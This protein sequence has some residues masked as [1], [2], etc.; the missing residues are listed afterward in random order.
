MIRRIKDYF[1]TTKIQLQGAASNR[2]KLLKYSGLVLGGAALTGCVERPAQP[3]E[4]RGHKNGQNRGSM[5]DRLAIRELI[6]SYNAAVIDN[7]ADAWADNWCADGVWNLGEESDIVG[8]ETI[9]KHWQEA[10][11]I[12]DFVGMFAQPKFIRVGDQDARA[13]WHTNELC[14]KSDGSMLRIF[15]LYRDAYRRELTGW[16]IAERRYSIL[17]ME[18]PIYEGNKVDDWR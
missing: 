1:D 11:Q 14:R 10:M 4:K 3:S 15:G 17:L 13:E 8:R 12:F 7:D 18:R 5:E 6:E 16:K 2:R 9:L